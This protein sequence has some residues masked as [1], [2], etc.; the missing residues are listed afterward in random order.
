M[1]ALRRKSRKK[2]AQITPEKTQSTTNHLLRENQTSR[3]IV[4]RLSGIQVPI[5]IR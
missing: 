4:K 3:M 2:N 1:I 5:H